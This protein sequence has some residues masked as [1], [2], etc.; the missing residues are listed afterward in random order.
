MTSRP[1][2]TIQPGYEEGPLQEI[3]LKEMELWRSGC[4]TPS[5]MEGYPTPPGA[6]SVCSCFPSER[7]ALEF[8]GRFS[9]FI[10]AYTSDS[11][12]KTTLAE[13]FAEAR[14]LKKDAVVIRR[15][16]GTIIDAYYVQESTDAA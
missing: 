8:R 7:D 16:N 6:R 15:G 13:V 10:I 11:P 12:Y 4:S 5:G 3:E 9:K 1:S 14:S 2:R